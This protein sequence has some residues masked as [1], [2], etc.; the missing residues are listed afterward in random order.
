MPPVD[1]HPT[2]EEKHWQPVWSSPWLV[3]TLLFLDFFFI[4]TWRNSSAYIVA[5]VDVTKPGFLVI[6]SHV[7]REAPPHIPTPEICLFSEK[8]L[9]PVFFPVGVDLELNLTGKAILR[10]FNK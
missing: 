5:R 4:D 10:C 7:P 3:D 9:V 8:F 1:S 2:P 6:A